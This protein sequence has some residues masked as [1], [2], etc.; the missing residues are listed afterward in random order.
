MKRLQEPVARLVLEKV[1]EHLILLAQRKLVDIRLEFCLR[2]PIHDAPPHGISAHR[3]RI[4]Q[5]LGA[6]F[7]V[8]PTVEI[9]VARNRHAFPR[10]YGV[11]QYTR[12][13]PLN[14]VVVG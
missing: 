11:G 3:P 4:I 6:Q 1:G 5:R 10:L 12:Q 14:N 2:R 9:H 13:Q 7:N 8:P